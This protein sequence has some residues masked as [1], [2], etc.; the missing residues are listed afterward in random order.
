MFTVLKRIKFNKSTD[1]FTMQQFKCKH[2][3]S[4]YCPGTMVEVSRNRHYLFMY[5]T[6][7][8]TTLVYKHYTLYVLLAYVLLFEV[9]FHFHVKQNKTVCAFCICMFGFNYVLTNSVVNQSKGM[10]FFLI[11]VKQIE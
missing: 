8:I 10:I 5:P 6:I 2:P 3:T 9:Y 7:D 4:N 1:F 11:L